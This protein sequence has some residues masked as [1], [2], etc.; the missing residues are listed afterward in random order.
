MKRGIGIF[1]IV[2]IEE[3]MVLSTL[4]TKKSPL[5][6]KKKFDSTQTYPPL[7]TMN[8]YSERDIHISSSCHRWTLN[9]W[10]NLLLVLLFQLQRI[11]R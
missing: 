8:V 4:T 9:R 1:I 2:V 5:H 3:S 6:P 10:T 7:I 11:H